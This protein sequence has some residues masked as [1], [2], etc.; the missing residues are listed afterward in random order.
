MG[1]LRDHEKDFIGWT[2]DQASILR[3]LSNRIPDLDSENLAEEIEDLGRAEIRE[4]SS[5]LRQTLIHL[6][7]LSVQSDADPARHW[8]DEALV[9]QGNAV[10]ACSPGIR[11]RIDLKNIWKLAVNAARRSLEQYGVDAGPLPEECPLSLDEL[12]DVD[13]DPVMCAQRISL[14]MAPQEL[15][16]SPSLG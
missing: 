10:I 5:L 16:D 7:K 13:F 15:G 3:R 6:I 14:S 12:L 1:I 2:E 4:T 9:F 11:Q 8:I